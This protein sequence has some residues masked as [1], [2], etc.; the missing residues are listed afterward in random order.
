M[1]FEKGQS[2]N[3]SGRPKGSLNRSTTELRETLSSLVDNNIDKIEI[4]LNR[5][6]K[7]DPK[8]AL[9]CLSSLMEYTLPKLN[10]STL[11]KDPPKN[12]N[13]VDVSDIFIRAL[14]E[15]KKED[16]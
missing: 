3:P 12:E 6:A 9:Q 11:P 7:E 15:A 1:P 16:P 4:W 10:R 8:A 13:N 5:I 2:G 14:E